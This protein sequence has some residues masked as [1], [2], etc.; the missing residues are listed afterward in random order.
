M[1]VERESVAFLLAGVHERRKDA[2]RL[3]FHGGVVCFLAVAAAHD[4][5]QLVELN[6]FVRVLVPVRLLDALADVFWQQDVEPLVRMVGVEA[7]MAA[8]CLLFWQIHR[9]VFACIR[10]TEPKLY[11]SPA[12]NDSVRVKCAPVLILCVR[13]P[14]DR[15]LGIYTPVPTL[16][17]V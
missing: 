16:V 3:H 14:L 12:L 10:Q 2:D 15:L 5:S 1:D 8:V 11:E 4:L 13:L 6:L 9:H 17:S 7:E